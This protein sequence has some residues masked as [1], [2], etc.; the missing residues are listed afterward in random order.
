FS[1]T[2]FNDTNSIAKL[3]RK[4][5]TF[6]PDLVITL[7]KGASFRPHYALLKCPEFHEKW[8]AY[9]H[10]PYPF[11][12]YPRPYNWVESG[13]KNKEAFFKAVSEKAA[14][15]AFPSLLLKEWM[16]SYFPNFLKTGIIIPH[17]SVAYEIKNK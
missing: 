11:H 8:L 6:K 12:Y 3:L 15:S 1:F 16:G 17:Q 2:F 10:D 9:V 14:F 13:F 5:K 4:E 7:S